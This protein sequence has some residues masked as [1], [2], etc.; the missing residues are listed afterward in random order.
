MPQKIVR[1][2]TPGRKVVVVG[3]GPAGLEA[4]RVLAERGHKVVLLEAANAL[5]GQV[6]LAA[7]ASW[8]R[9]LIGIVDWRA[10]ELEHLGVDVRLNTYAEPEDVQALQ[11]DIVIVATGGVPGFGEIAGAEHAT[12]PWDLIDGSAA[13][14]DRRA[15]L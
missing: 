5:G 4:A 11:P 15:D 12:S 9:D 8:R 1:S 3:G 14:A 10:H 13:P 7:E 2:A 6:R